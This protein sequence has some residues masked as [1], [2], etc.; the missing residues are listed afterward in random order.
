MELFCESLFSYSVAFLMMSVVSQT[1]RPFNADFIRGN[2]QKSAGA[3]SEVWA[4]LQCW[5]TVLCYK[6]FTETDRCAGALSWRG[7]QPL[8]LHFS[9]RFLLTASLGW[10]RISVHVTLFTVKNPVNYTSEFGEFF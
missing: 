9:G 2:T 8:L 10:R 1:R 5:H 4:M 6:F 3:R 7:N